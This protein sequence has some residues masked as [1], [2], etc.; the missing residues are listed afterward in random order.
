MPL[1][2]AFLMLV[3]TAALAQ[4][5]EL[6]TLKGEVLKGDLVSVD[7]TAVVFKIEGKDVSTP[8]E[9]VLAI[10]LSMAPALKDVKYTDVELTD[11]SLLHCKEVQLKGKKAYLVLLGEQKVEVPLSSVT[12][13]MNEA[14]DPQNRNEWK[15]KVIAKK[16]LVD[17]LVI[18]RNEVMN[19]IP[20]TLS[21]PSEDGT[22]INF[23]PEGSDKIEYTIAKAFGFYFV[24]KPDPAAPSP[25]CKLTDVSRNLVY[26]SEVTAGATGITVTTPAGAKIE[27]KTPQVANLDYRKGKLTY[28]SEID[29]VQVIEDSTEDVIWHYRRDTNIEGGEIRIA[30]TPYRRGLALH[31]HT[32]LV[33]DLGGQYREF[34]ALA[35]I[36]DLVNGNDEKIVLRIEADGQQRYELVITRKDKQRSHPITLNVKDVDKLRIIV[37]TGDTLDYGKHLDL[38]EARVSK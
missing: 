33:Y 8:I 4:A 21:D 25:V 28:L 15:T 14:Q 12:S 11:G 30:G 29:P 2:R 22:K 9:Q 32:E 36:D 10:D 19:P 38:A 16:S 24:Q 13:V 34:R 27:Y 7:K 31:S 20:G 17:L 26:A 35:G 5:A 37:T 18:K 6:K 1:C 3:L 23:T